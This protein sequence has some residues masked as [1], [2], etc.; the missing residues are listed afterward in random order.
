[1]TG[2]VIETARLVLRPPIESDLDSWAGFMADAVATRFVGGTQA[3]SVAWRGM[4]TMAGCW[5]L[6]G[7]GMFSVVERSSGRWVGRIG[8]WQPEGWPG[9]EIGWSLVRDVW[10]LGY[11]T[12]GASAAIDWALDTLGWSEIIHVI[13]PENAASLAVAARLGST[14]HGPGRLPVP[15]QDQRV[16]IWGQT[17]NV[18]R[19]RRG[20]V[21]SRGDPASGE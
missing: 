19:K 17:A 21:L 7:F 6:R 12:E 4:A 5:A 16:D 20:A 8:P 18:W 11:A 14:H 1:M 2:P 15:Y 3:R 10:G 13:D 9:P